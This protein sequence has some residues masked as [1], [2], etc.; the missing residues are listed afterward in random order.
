[1]LVPEAVDQ[2]LVSFLLDEPPTFVVPKY[3]LVERPRIRLTSI[4]DD[5]RIAASSPVYEIV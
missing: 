4:P 1:M 3:R 2:P 5:S